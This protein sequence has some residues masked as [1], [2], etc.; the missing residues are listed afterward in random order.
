MRLQVSG[1]LTYL[2]CLIYI[3]S[4]FLYLLPFISSPSLHGTRCT[5][6]LGAAMPASPDIRRE[7]GS[8]LMYPFSKSSSEARGFTLIKLLIVV[9]IIAILA[10]IAVPN[11]LEAQ[12]RAK[13]SRAQNDMRALATALE[14]YR[15]DHNKYPPIAAPNSPLAG[16]GPLGLST[17]GGSGINGASIFLPGTSG[18]SSRFIWITTPVAYISSVFRDPFIPTTVGRALDPNPPNNPNPQYDTYDYA[19]AASVWPGGILGNCTTCRG[20]SITSGAGYHVV[21]AGP[22]LIN[23]F[24]G[25]TEAYSNAERLLGQDYD[26][27]NGTTSNGDI[28]RIAA[29]PGE[30][31][32]IRPSINRVTN[33]WLLP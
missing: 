33:T 30:F 31:A 19:D 11:F 13:V 24:G 26:P 2:V 9:A 1:R 10:A 14:T 8:A 3:R 6:R 25:G 32:T 22:D 27:T 23:S 20:A 16:G 17:A 12:V 4:F 5:R 7:G 21:S 18:I 15:V 28:V 29:S